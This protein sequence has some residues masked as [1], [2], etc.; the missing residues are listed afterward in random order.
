MLSLAKPDNDIVMP[1][2]RLAALL[3]PGID[4][5]PEVMLGAGQTLFHGYPNT[6]YFWDTCSYV[7]LLPLAVLAVLLVRAV[8]ARRLPRMPWAFVTLLGGGAL[9][10]S[11]RF[12]EPLRALV[13]GTLFRSPA[14]LLYLATFAAAVALGFGVTAFLNGN[15]L[16]ARARQA[17]VAACLLLHFLDLGG[18]SRQ[19]VRTVHY[20]AFG[21][22]A[23]NGILAREI[24]GGRVAADDELADYD[25]AGGFDSLLLANPYRAILGVAG[26]PLDFNEEMLDGS[27]LPIP[28]LQVAGVRFVITVED[29]PDLEL[30]KASGGD[31]LYR[32]PDPVRRAAFFAGDR[33]RFLPRGNLLDEF[34][35]RRQ[36]GELL[37]PTESRTLPSAS[38]G[39]LRVPP[40]A[41]Y[42]RPSS[43]EIRLETTS[44]QAGFAHVLESWDPGWSAQVDGQRAPVAIANGFSMAVPVEA[45]RHA[46]RLRYQTAGRTA[47][48]ILSLISGGL[49]AMLLWS[50]RGRRLPKRLVRNNP[51]NKLDRCPSEPRP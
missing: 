27:T 48:W 37:L 36:P 23:F 49:L 20:T 31:F 41:S 35:A 8:A 39:N 30:V 9:L 5:W 43:D 51:S 24:Q 10:F 16:K 42:F 45:G 22:Q 7:G 46:I 40:S 18:F 11:L 28:A 13:P 21:T 2:G 17:I 4:G 26:H 33:V 50:A 19:F 14:R 44:G 32:V 29:R 47:G 6:A 12:A 3:R 15:F 38:G 1:L 34:L 25:D